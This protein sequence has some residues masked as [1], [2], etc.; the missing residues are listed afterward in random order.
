MVKIDSG[1]S[2]YFR[3]SR[4]D[5]TG[6]SGKP[7]KTD[8]SSATESGK[9]SSGSQSVAEKIAVSDLGKEVA[10]I[11]EEVK[12]TPEVRVEKVQELKA[13]IDD[14]TYYVSSDRIAEKILQD[15]ISQG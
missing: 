8:S 11:H 13:K 6:K 5:G 3:K 7:D 14:G 1:D 2:G 10:R 9:A 15:I 4:I 12:K